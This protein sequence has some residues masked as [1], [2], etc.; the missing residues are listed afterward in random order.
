M[1]YLSKK[2]M[3]FSKV[4]FQTNCQSR[5]KKGTNLVENVKEINLCI[6]FKAL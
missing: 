3:A 4:K 2:C 1:S 6:T 5:L